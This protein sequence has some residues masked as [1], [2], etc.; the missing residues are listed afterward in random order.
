MSMYAVGSF[1]DASKKSW[2]SKS[3]PN[4]I[5]KDSDK[6]DNTTSC[7]HLISHE[8][9][10]IPQITEI[11]THQKYTVFIVF[12]NHYSDF[13]YTNIIKGNPTEEI[14][15]TIRA[16]QWV[17]KTHDVLKINHYHTYNIRFNDKELIDD[18]DNNGNTY[19]YCG[20]GSY[21][22]NGVAESKNTLFHIEKEHLITRKKA[23][24]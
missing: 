19:S 17:T 9:G 7:D 12:A 13:T 8:P 6:R 1:V 24:N 23:L 14:T 11:L 5:R 4:T 21:H 2:R 18:C 20:V 22:N 15:L 16:Y 3:I 10:M